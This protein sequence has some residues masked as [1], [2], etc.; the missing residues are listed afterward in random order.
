MDVVTTVSL[1]DTRASISSTEIASMN[2]ISSVI[3]IFINECFLTVGVFVPK[4]LKAMGIKDTTNGKNT[5]MSK[6]EKL[7]ALIASVMKGTYNVRLINMK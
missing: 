1:F 6:D 3:E 5:R 4:N 7:D 2:V